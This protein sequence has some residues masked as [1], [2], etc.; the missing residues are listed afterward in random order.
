MA[1]DFSI[2]GI[3]IHA[4]ATGAGVSINDLAG[5][6][7]DVS[8]QTPPGEE[9]DIDIG[10]S[11]LDG[12]STTSAGPEGDLESLL[13]QSSLEPSTT[14]GDAGSSPAGGEAGFDQDTLS[15]LSL[16]G[17]ADD[18]AGLNGVDPLTG[19]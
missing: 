3:G 8:V 18:T 13:G 7:L 12:T 4:G 10:L 1:L 6:G 16:L 17:G 2:D 14:T 11:G 5:L 15:S 19:V 9:P